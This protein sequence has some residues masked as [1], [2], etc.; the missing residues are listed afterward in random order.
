MAE[1][2]RTRIQLLDALRG[3]SILLMVAYH[4]GYDLVLNGFLPEDVLYNPFLNTLQPIFAGIFITL[5]GISS[6]FSR[7][8]LKRGLITLGAAALVSL[9]G[10]VM[11]MPIWFGILHLLSACMLLYWLLDKLRVMTVA[12]PLAAFAVLFA[13]VTVF[14]AL[15]DSNDF[16]PLVPWGFLFFAG[17]LLGDPIKAGKLPR[18]FY[19]AKIP[20]FSNVGRHTLII[21]LAHQP[22]LFGVMWVLLRLFPRGA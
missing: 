11:G 7:S 6:R 9:A 22:V 19:E 13:G 14:P 16:F 4:C 10:Y 18:W 15:Q 21:Y 1:S 2:T 5:A 12:V 17:A 20:F 3:L 8:N